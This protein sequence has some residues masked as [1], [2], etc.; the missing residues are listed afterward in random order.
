ME[1]G[2]SK[3]PDREPVRIMFIDHT[4]KLSG[5]EIALLRLISALDRSRFAV[6]VVLFSNGE[7]VPELR[8]IGIEP[9]ILPLH[10]DVLNTRKESLSSSAIFR[11]GTLPPILNHI[12]SLKELIKREKPDLVHTNSLKSDIIG[13]IAARLAR[14]PVIWHIRDRCF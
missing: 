7:F 12:R 2:N 5:G 14:V 3:L 10:A 11:L 1:S 13:G 6:S 8:K 4:A 9:T